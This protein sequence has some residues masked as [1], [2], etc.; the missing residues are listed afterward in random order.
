MKKRITCLL[1]AALLALTCVLAMASC[2]N[3]GSGATTDN[4]HTQCVDADKDGKCDECGKAVAP[5]EPDEPVN[6]DEPCEHVDE[7]DDGWCDVCDEELE[8]ECDHY[9][10]DKDGFCDDCEEKL[11]APHSHVDNDGDSYCDECDEK[12]DIKPEV[13]YNYPWTTQ[14]LIFQLT[15]NT[16]K[17]ELPAASERYLAGEDN[18]YSEDIDDM[19]MDRNALAEYYTKVK[20]RYEYYPNTDDYTW[21]KNID[22]IETTV[23]S[24]STKDAPDVYVNFVYDLVGA[25]LKASFA[26][27]YSTR[28]GQGELKGKNYF[29]FLD[30]NYN[31]EVDNRGYM[32]EYMTSLTLSKHKMYVLASDYFTDLVRSFHI[33][34][35]S[36]KLIEDIGME[37]TGDRDGDGEFTLDDFYEQVKA[38]EWTYDLLAQYSAKVYKA[39]GDNSTGECWLGDEIV[40][41]AMSDGGLAATGILYTSSVVVIHKTWNEGRNDWDYY[42]PEDSPDLYAFCEATTELFTSPGVCLVTGSNVTQWG[43]SQLL[44]IRTRFSENHVLFGDIM[45]VGALEFEQYQVMKENGGFGIVPV[46]VYREGDKY[47]TL[48]HAVGMPGAISANTTKFAECTAFLNY[49]STHSTDI[50][51]EYYNYKLQYDVADGTK[52]T[53]YMLQYI[54]SNVRTYFDKCFEDAIGFFYDGAYENKW[55]SIIVA[56]DYKLDIRAD[57]KK[58]YPAKAEYLNGLVLMYDELPD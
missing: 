23:K 46:P 5:D 43:S 6:P 56:A 53:V 7:D 28:R 12:M 58:H 27:L 10:Y 4:T 55:L 52:G 33:V 22:R 40:G 44:A 20:V 54:R 25:S 11:E 17:D 38:G 34:P 1:L 16:N 48:I 15:R 32:Y 45:M 31:E 24:G 9:D 21:G 26:N 13:V 42:Y 14:T 57:Y 37:I 51:D 8:A 50:L 41:F 39:A 29:E 3:E 30:D 19:V 36:V 2:G 47:L 18:R 49:Q 35:V